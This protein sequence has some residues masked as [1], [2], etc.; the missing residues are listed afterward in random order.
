M[1]KKETNN[2]TQLCLWEGTIVKDSEIKKF[3]SWILE[4]LGARIKYEAQ[5]KTNPDPGKPKTGG[6]N[7]LFFFVYVEDIPSFSVKR[8]AY[9]IRW[10]EDIFFNHQEYLYPQEF[11]DK[12]PRTW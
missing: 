12:H 11:I 3:E 1:S 2:F 9:H 7:D 4:E 10:W 5:V 8:F 6:R